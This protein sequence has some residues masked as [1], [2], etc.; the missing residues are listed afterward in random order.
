MSIVH[1]DRRNNFNF[2]RLLF[3]SLVLLSHSSE[4]LDGNRE[5]EPL[6]AIFHTIS[7][8]DLAVDGFF[9]LSGYLIVQSWQLNPSW[10]RFLKKRILR[11]Y[12]AF[13]VASLVCAFIV[14]P[15]GSDAAAYFRAFDAPTFIRSMFL[16]Y[17]PITPQVFEGSPAPYVNGAMWTTKHEFRC[18]LM[19]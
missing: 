7:F 3:A 2:L 19:V 17:D 11:I 10:L 18:Y 13:I 16:L 6:F 5:R 14:G 4:L 9:L 8:G 12:P 15:L 1:A